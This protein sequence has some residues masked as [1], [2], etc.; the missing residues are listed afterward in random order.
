MIVGLIDKFKGRIRVEI[1]WFGRF[2][3]SDV[4]G[5]LNAV[6]IELLVMENFVKKKKKMTTFRIL[7]RSILFDQVLTFQH[8]HRIMLFMMRLLTSCVMR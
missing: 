5:R 6:R 2:R 8:S 3:A 1:L 7:D 4:V